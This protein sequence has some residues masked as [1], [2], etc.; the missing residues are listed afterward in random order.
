MRYPAAN[1]NV[2]PGSAAASSSSGM[3]TRVGLTWELPAPWNRGVRANSPITAM[4]WP[5]T[6]ASGSTPS[7][8]S[9]TMLCAAA[10]RARAWCAPASR[11]AVS[12]RRD[13]STSRSTRPAARSR[14]ASSRSPAATASMIAR[15]LTPSLGGI[16]RSSPARS[17]ATRSCTAPQSETTIPSK[18][19][20][21]RSTSVSSHRCWAAYTP[22]TLL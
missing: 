3:S 19:H 15:S 21:S 7:F 13:R 6:S 20:S 5:V 4:V 17:A 9:S 10:R 2:A 12:R 14:M 22:L 8:F 11:V 1:R 18:P 16:S